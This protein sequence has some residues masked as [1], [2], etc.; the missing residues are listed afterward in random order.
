MHMGKNNDLITLRVLALLEEPAINNPVVILHD[1][2]SNRVLPIWIGEPEARAIAMVLQSVEISRPL[3]HTLFHNTINELGADLDYVVIDHLEAGTYFATLYLKRPPKRNPILI[4]A[5]PSDA[6]VLALEGEV[7]IYIDPV[8]FE[9][10]GQENPFPDD[11]LD[12]APLSSKNIQH[13]PRKDFTE[14]ELKD[15]TEL[16]RKAR[17]REQL[18]D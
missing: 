5:R 9:A 8:V 13:K 12:E 17:E 1:P 3:T 14:K 15:L 11:L 18:T 16:L 2:E 4:D 10:A 7:P 6:I